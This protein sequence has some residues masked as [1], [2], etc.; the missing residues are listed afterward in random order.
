[1]KPGQSVSVMGQPSDVTLD[2]ADE[3]P[4]VEDSTADA[5]VIFCP[6]RDELNKRRKALVAAGRRDALAWLAYPK[7][8]KV[9]TDL[10]RELLLRELLTADGFL[11][12][13]SGS[14]EPRVVGVALA[15][16]LRHRLQGNPRFGSFPRSGLR[17]DVI[18]RL[19]R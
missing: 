8:A 11:A 15:S 4:G 5:V 18:C 12:R 10:N 14:C 1:M 6:R 2:L 9:D 13:P 17:T 19:P 7:A 16:S 3:C